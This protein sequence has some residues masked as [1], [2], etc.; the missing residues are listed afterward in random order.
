MDV[1]SS[2]QD[3]LGARD[4]LDAF[5]TNAVQRVRAVAVVD[6]VDVDVDVGKRLR[7]VDASLS[8]RQAA[9]SFLLRRM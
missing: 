4:R 9:P 2:V 3:A 5:V 8:S 7:R 6:V 1:S